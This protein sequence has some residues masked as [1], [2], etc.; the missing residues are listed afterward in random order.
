MLPFVDEK[1]LFK[2]LEPYYAA[3]SPEEIKRNIR[4]DDKL[5]VSPNN[6]GY[7]LIK[8]LYTQKI[9]YS[10]ETA[11]CIDGM[12]GTVLITEESVKIGG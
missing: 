11:I 7:D 8:C 3:L 6:R 12:K 9:E 4:G 5:Y 2:A 1:R 10:A